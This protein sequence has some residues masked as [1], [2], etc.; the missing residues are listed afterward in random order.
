MQFKFVF[1]ANAEAVYAPAIFDDEIPQAECLVPM[2]GHTY[3]AREQAMKEQ[4][5]VGIDEFGNVWVFDQVA[6]KWMSI[7]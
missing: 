7:S 2:K 4:V 3:A 6:A 1:P 5:L